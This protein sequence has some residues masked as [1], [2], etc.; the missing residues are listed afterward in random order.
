MVFIGI[1]PGRNGGLSMLNS[2][3]ECLAS[4]KMPFIEDS[5]DVQAIVMFLTT[6]PD[7]QVAVERVSSMPGQGVSSV[8][9][10]GH[11]VG[12]LH[13]ILETLQIPYSLIGPVQWQKATCGPTHGIKAVTI[14]W[15]VKRFPTA[16]LVP[17]GC[18]KPHDGIADSLGI[19]EW[20][21]LREV[22]A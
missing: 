22:K 11:T 8:F 10:F 3:G 4:I 21:R 13:G 12:I 6:A 2:A 5:L 20:L 16:Q 7:V 19:A 18:R 9:K 15:A 14:N 1:D 17:K